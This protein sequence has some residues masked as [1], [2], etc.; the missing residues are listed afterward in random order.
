M[1]VSLCFPAYPRQYVCLYRQACD[2]VAI[3]EKCRQQA[4][5]QRLCRIPMP[6]YSGCRLLGFQ[7]CAEYCHVHADF[8]CISDR[9]R[10]VFALPFGE[11]TVHC[12]R[13]ALS[14][15]TDDAAYG[16]FAVWVFLERQKGEAHLEQFCFYEF[17]DD[18]CHMRSMEFVAVR[19]VV[20]R[21]YRERVRC[22]RHAEFQCATREQAHCAGSC[23]I[24]CKRCQYL[25]YIPARFLLLRGW[26]R[27]SCLRR[28]Y[29]V[30]S[31]LYRQQLLQ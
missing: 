17:F 14:A 15:G 2:E 1:S 7:A 5:I 29:L 10:T 16:T 25:F 12:L 4:D 27:C 30:G 22:V 11:Q 3:E 20:F 24:P 13:P 31:R 28:R 21:E 19:A 23:R 26:H 18:L 6:L 9:R 8:F